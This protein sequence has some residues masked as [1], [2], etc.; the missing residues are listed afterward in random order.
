VDFDICG[1]WLN[2]RRAACAAAASTA[3]A[4]AIASSG[5]A[6]AA[7]IKATAA[8]PTRAVSSIGIS[9]N[10]AHYSRS[11]DAVLRSMTLFVFATPPAATAGSLR[12]TMA[13]VRTPLPTVAICTA[14]A[15]TATSRSAVSILVIAETADP[16]ATGGDQNAVYRTAAV[17]AYV[18][19]TA[20]V[21][22]VAIL[23]TA[24]ALSPTVKSAI[25]AVS[26]NVDY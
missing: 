17:F 18:W 19:C 7:A 20:A 2:V 12:S 24:S 3:V 25:A 26:A 11:S 23:R 22:T 10:A 9:A 13:P 5:T 6:A 8:T 1:V 21:T 14:L 4:T 15:I 16:A